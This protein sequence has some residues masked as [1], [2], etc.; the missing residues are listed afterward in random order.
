M[1]KTKHMK[2]EPYMKDAYHEC[3][4]FRGKFQLEYIT[5]TTEFAESEIRTVKTNN[6]KLIRNKPNGSGKA[7]IMTTASCGGRRWKL[8]VPRCTN[9]WLWSKFIHVYRI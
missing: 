4:L 6:A 9:S 5:S 8:H 1:Y 7:P 3:P 2:G